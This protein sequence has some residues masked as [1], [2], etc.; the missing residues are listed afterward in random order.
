MF[1]RPHHQKI[2]TILAKLNSDLLEKEQCYFAGGT[3]IALKFGEFRE[4]VDIDFMT[5]NIA[6]YRN[7]RNQIRGTNSLLPLLKE[8]EN[9]N[10]AADIRADQYGIRTKIITDDSLIKFE[11]VLEGR[12]N[13]DPPKASDNIAGVAC[14]TPVD[15]AASKILANSDRGLD[16]ATHTRDII[17][18]A[19]M[20]QPK[21]ILKKALQKATEAYGESALNDL[22]KVLK[23]LEAKPDL[24]EK[25][26]KKMAME[27]PQSVV[28]QKLRKLEKSFLTA[29]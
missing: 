12:I 18:L 4:S 10:L 1:N 27:L 22:K 5:S 21:S 28:W 20:D 7:L 13:F 17:D 11:I 24:L 2:A 19:M 29:Q 25:N 16:V 8:G 23:N 14:L 6:S 15:L 26:I 9:L 3:A